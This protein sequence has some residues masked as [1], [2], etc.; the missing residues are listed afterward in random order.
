M[1]KK[2]AGHVREL[3]QQRVLAA[4]QEKCEAARFRAPVDTGRLRNSIRAEADGL[5]ARVIA[6]CEYAAAVEF[7]TN[8]A[9]PHPFMRGE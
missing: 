8:R 7:G 6:D 2:F 3:T 4:A 5:I 1:L 9:A